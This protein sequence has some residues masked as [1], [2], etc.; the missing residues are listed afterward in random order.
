MGLITSWRITSDPADMEVTNASVGKMPAAAH[1]ISTGVHRIS[2]GVHRMPT[3]VHRIQSGVHRIQSGVHRAPTDMHRI[4]TAVRVIHTDVDGVPTRGFLGA[5]PNNVARPSMWAITGRKALRSLAFVK[6]KPAPTSAP[7]TKLNMIAPVFGVSPVSPP[8]APKH[9]VLKF[10]KVGRCFSPH[11]ITYR[12]PP[13][14][15][16][17]GFLHVPHTSFCAMSYC[18]LSCHP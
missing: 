2:T 8:P 18:T 7:P 5:S 3:G 10:K 6:R 1:R 17:A 11:F 16:G 9:Q 14:S 4:P 12:H 13:C 15:K